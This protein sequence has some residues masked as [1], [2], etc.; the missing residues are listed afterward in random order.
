MENFSFIGKRIPI[1]DAK[2]KVT[3]EAKYAADL[4][5]P[6]MLYGKILRSPHPHAKIMNIDISLAKKVPGVKAI[7]TSE[8]TPKIKVG[9]FILDKYILAVDKVRYI[10]EE[11]A[12]VAAIDEDAAEEARNLIKVDYDILPAVF[13]VEK[14][15][16]RM[17]PGSTRKQGIILPCA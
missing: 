4:K 15:S 13:D 7:V 5:L 2:E 10:G 8:Q 3:G 14:R 11:V 6:H 9:A 12:A 16:C 17:H 1:I